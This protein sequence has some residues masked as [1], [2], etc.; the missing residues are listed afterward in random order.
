MPVEPIAII[1]PGEENVMEGGPAAEYR[2]QATGKMQSDDKS[3]S[4]GHG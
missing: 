1:I 3:S 2:F 4:W